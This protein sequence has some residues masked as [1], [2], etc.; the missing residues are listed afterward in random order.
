MQLSIA[1]AN[2]AANAVCAL[3]NNGYIRVYTGPRPA[4]T[5]V[6]LTT[7]VL[8]AQ[9]R[10]NTTAFG[11]AAGA[12]AV[13]NSITEDSSTPNGGTAVW[14]RLFKADGTTVIA[15]GSVGVG[16]LDLSTNDGFDMEVTTTTIDA[17]RRFAPTGMQYTQT[18]S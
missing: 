4:S 15:D 17:G 11:P 3:L 7:Q 12:V 5:E 1:A 6:A 10:L 13:A 16:D 2:A 18:R 9:P 14:F 8:L